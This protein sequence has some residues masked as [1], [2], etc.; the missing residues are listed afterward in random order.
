MQENHNAH[1]LFR[2]HK[3]FINETETIIP[4]YILHQSHNLI[5]VLK[6]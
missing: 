4:R 2:N 6:P 1:D 3:N 5:N